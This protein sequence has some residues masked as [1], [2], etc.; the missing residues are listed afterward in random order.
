MSEP[1]KGQ[2]VTFYSYKGGTG[3]TM[4]LANVAWILAAAGKRVLVADWD[5]EAPGLHKFFRPFLDIDTVADAKGVIDL[6]VPDQDGASDRQGHE[7]DQQTR[8]NPQMHV[9]PE[10]A[11]PRKR[12]HGRGSLHIRRDRRASC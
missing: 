7:R 4:A 2:V 1:R 10:S 6:I 11:Q 8:A 3:R 12:R 9:E 5:L